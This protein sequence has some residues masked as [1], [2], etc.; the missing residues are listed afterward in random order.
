MNL[1]RPLRFT[2][3]LVALILTVGCD[4]STKHLARTKLNRFDSVLLLGGLGEFR[5]AENPGAFLSLGAALP[6]AVRTTVFTGATGV[7]M[8]ALL[9]ALLLRAQIRPLVFAGL[10]LVL[11]GGVGNLI[12]RIW[13]HGLVTDFLTLRCGPLQTGIFNGADVLVMIG[14]TL[15]ALAAWQSPRAPRPTNVLPD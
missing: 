4:Q 13:R 1:S 12:D 9:G 2:V 6:P 10:T 14:L 7:G 11:A 5:L 8:L 3:L 15:L